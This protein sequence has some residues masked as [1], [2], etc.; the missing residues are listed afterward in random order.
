LRE[1]FKPI[2]FES[3]AGAV[4]GLLVETPDKKRTLFVGNVGE[5]RLVIVD[6]KKFIQATEDAKPDKEKFVRSVQA[7][8]GKVVDKRSSEPQAVFY[9]NSKGE[10]R[11]LSATSSLGM[12]CAP[13]LSSKPTITCYTELE[14]HK[15]LT[16]LLGNRSIF[17]VL[18]SR[19]VAAMV[20]EGINEN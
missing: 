16:L 14:K 7:R 17:K 8:G 19:Q 5:S 4:V 13:S 18:S 1:R 3:G 6:D 2:D 15:K 12:A 9:R 11:R 20:Q 10:C